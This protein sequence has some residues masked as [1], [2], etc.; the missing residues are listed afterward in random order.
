MIRMKTLGW[1]TMTVL[2]VFFS[3][4]AL[5]IFIVPAGRQPL[6]SVLLTN[7]PYVAP[8]HFVG[9]AIALAIGAFQLNAT[10]RSRFLSVHRWIGRVYLVS[11]FFSS[12][13]GF[14]L[15][16][17]SSGGLIAQIGFGLLAAS[18]FATTT[19]AYRSIRRGDVSEHRSW[20]IRSYSLTLAAV[21]LRLYI[22]ASAALDISI[23]VA[24]PAIAWLCW[25]PNLFV[26][27]W[28]VGAKRSLPLTSDT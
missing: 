14:A 21:T 18:W 13:A 2:A 5:S 12:L 3:W 22:P 15:A 17:Q 23:G 19:L 28:F 10:L 24:Y 7:H 9:G 4:Y 16:T 27:E 11:V 1:I 6:V 25:V 20:M 26:A 8:L